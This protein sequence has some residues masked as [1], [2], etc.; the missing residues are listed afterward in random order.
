MAHSDNNTA[1]VILAAGLGSRFDGQKQ[2][3]PVSPSGESIMEYSMYDAIQCGCSHIVMVV[4]NTF[5]E[6]HKR[7][8]QNIARQ[9]HVEIDFV[10]QQITSYVPGKYKSHCTTRAK[11]WGTAHAI[12]M[13]KE[14]VTT[15]FI[16]INAD[17]FYGRQAYATAS[18]AIRQHAITPTAYQM[19]AYRLSATLSDNGFVSRGLCITDESHYLR[20]IEEHPRIHAPGGDVISLGGDGPQ[21]LLKDALVSMNFWIFHPSV[22]TH[23][24]SHFLAFLNECASD[25]QKE[26]FIT[27]VIDD[28]IKTHTITMK[29][30]SS[31]QPWFGITYRNDKLS[32]SEKLLALTSENQYPSPLWK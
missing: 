3:E 28:L 14:F 1:L 25:R 19:V 5:D 12:L 23:L 18:A 30:N 2:V 24:E 17:D 31:D 32:V 20:E 4:N 7:T 15:P 6:G 16:V 8:F 11:P 27:R 9:Q 29:V 22:F 21:I 10:C 26:F 13:A